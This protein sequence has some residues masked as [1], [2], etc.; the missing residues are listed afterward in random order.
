MHTHSPNAWQLA[1]PGIGFPQ[2]ISVGPTVL[3]LAAAWRSVDR[4]LVKRLIQTTLTIAVLS[5][6]C[7]AARRRRGR[8]RQA[9]SSL[10]G[11]GVLGFS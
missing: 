7:S 6:R 5:S 4:W 8:S 3:N 11:Y 9:L 2:P 1:V 10:S